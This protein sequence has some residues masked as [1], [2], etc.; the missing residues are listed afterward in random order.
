MITGM[1]DLL[2]AV[3]GVVADRAVRSE[4]LP[5]GLLMAGAAAVCV[6]IE[7]LTDLQRPV[8]RVRSRLRRPCLRC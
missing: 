6:S 3:W 1:K 5:L 2:A 4:L 8:R 7:W